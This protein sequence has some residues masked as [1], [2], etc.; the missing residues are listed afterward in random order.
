M[1]QKILRA[2]EVN[3]EKAARVIRGGGLVIFPTDTVYGLGCD[4]FNREAVRKIF[5]V[6]GRDEKK[7]LPILIADKKQLKMLVSD[8]PPLAKE[9]MK[10]YWPARN[11]TAPVRSRS[12]K[13]LNRTSSSQ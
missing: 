8:V 9:L 10:K 6:K 5:V 4:A 3:I 1:E 7:S 2:T 12:L 13:P 11:S